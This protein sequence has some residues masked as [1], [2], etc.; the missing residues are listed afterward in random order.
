LGNETINAEKSS[1]IALVCFA[2]KLC[3]FAV[4]FYRKERKGLR[5]VR[6]QRNNILLSPHGMSPLR[7]RLRPT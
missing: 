2:S 5:K 6:Y 3:A 7:L 1:I 4:I